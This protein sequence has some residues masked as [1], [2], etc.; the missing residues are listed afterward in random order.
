MIQEL[1]ASMIASFKKCPRWYELE[2]IH[3]L[4]PVTTSE[5]L[6]VGT[7]YH[8]NVEKILRHEEYSH[9]GLSGL[10]SKLCN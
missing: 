1:T 4:K 8:A 6:S 5:A 10:S 3:E 2:Y 9:E 7:D